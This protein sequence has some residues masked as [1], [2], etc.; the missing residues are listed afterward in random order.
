MA[1]TRHDRLRPFFYLLPA[2]LLLIVFSI[3]P[4]LYGLIVSFC[5]WG[6]T[7]ERF[8][9]LG[10]YYK[11]LLDPEFRQSLTVTIYYVIGTVPVGLILSYIIASLLVQKL[12]G[13]G[14]YR[15]IYFLPY[16]TSTVAAAAIWKWI[17]HPG[18][19]GLANGLLAW[20]GGLVGK[21]DMPAVLWVQD[22]RS[23]FRVFGEIIGVDINWGG[24]S[25]ALL[26]VI[27]FSIWHSLGF[28]I[29]IFLA[30]LSA[31]PNEVNEA[32]MIDGARGWKMARHI[33]LPLISPT[34][35]FLLVISVIRAF[36]AFNQIYVMI[37]EHAL[38]EAQNVT[39][40]IFS[41]FYNSGEVGYGSAA[42]FV[43]FLIIMLLTVAQM[44]LLSKMTH[45]S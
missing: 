27:I 40:F 24:P 11:V 16:I 38:P 35:V 8:V 39:F 14:A 6:I 17:F 18:D 2:A 23:I 45:Y 3:L 20:I 37:G 19:R 33:T 43:L 26:C 4:V 5:R 25:V 13:M 29:V 10:N 12:R 41:K 28:N 30:A 21:A 15:T 7:Y 36:Q 9:G 22:P 34:I 31:L 32:A 1:T 44:R 42:A